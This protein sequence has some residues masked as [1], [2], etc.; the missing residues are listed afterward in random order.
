MKPGL[1]LSMLLASLPGQPLA[2]QD[3][4]RGAAEGAIQGKRVTVEYGRAALRGR[5]LDSL[6]AQL[7]D[8][9]VWRA[10]ADEVTTFTTEGDL[11]VEG[12]TGT[13][14]TRNRRPSPGRRV[15]AGKYSVYISAPTEG[16]WLL[17]LNS[18]P[19]I[20]LGALTKALGLSVPDRAAKR[21]W[22]HLEGYNLD[23]AHNVPGIA[24][25]EVVRVVMTPG[26]VS[27]AVDPFTISFLP[28]GPDTL[29]LIAAW[30]DRSWSVDLHGVGAA[31]DQ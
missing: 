14:C 19:G 12:L 7:P 17:I 25:S 3:A 5:S 13:A 4:P 20:E 27:P 15:P 11:S 21:L 16:N 26:T 2:A 24:S 28:S 8:D 9:R 6:I 30:A 23:R 18:D 31:A 10:G 1:L 22:P 29:T